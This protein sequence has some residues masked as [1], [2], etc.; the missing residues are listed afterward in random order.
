[1]TNRQRLARPGF[2]FFGLA[3]VIG[4]RS[5]TLQLLI[6]IGAPFMAV[7]FLIGIIAYASAQDEISE[8]YDSQLIRSAQ[9]LWTMIR[10][11]DDTDPLLVDRRDPNLD[12][13]DQEALDD[14]GRRSS[15][16]VWRDGRLLMASQGGPFTA[17]A[18]MPRGFTTM[19]TASGDWRVFTFVVP[20]DGI[21]VE[22]SE[23]LSARREV[24]S[25][26]VWGVSLPLLV[27]LP[28]IIL[29]VWLA[30]RWGLRDLRRFASDI[31]SRSPDDL[32]RVGGAD[33]PVEIAPVAEAV[34]QLLDKLERSAAQ[35]RLFTDNAAH[36]L[37]T[38]LA[39][40]VV[41]ADVI[42]NATTDA[43]RT[44]MI[45]ELSK[46]VARA[47]RLLDQLL[48][49][50]RIRHTPVEAQPLQLYDLAGEVIR[51]HY[52]KAR[53]RQIELSLSG[54]EA[55]VVTS[56]KAMLGL[57]IGNLVDNAIK[58]SPPGTA[59]EVSVTFEAE[60]ACLLVRDQGPGIPEHERDQVFNR[61]YRMKGQGETG[62]GL[63]LSIV[64]TLGELLSAK[65]TLFTPDTD[66]GLG[67]RV[68]FS[69]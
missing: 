12:A 10:Q 2:R 28:I 6:A 46:G 64:R 40:L 17:S 9:Q 56:S 19:R 32:S 7:I 30:I 5:L 25:R 23:R 11:D 43:D 26:I 54:D 65:I 16:R 18:P 1:M 47:S 3:A 22:A 69:R 57:L 37:R 21:V 55:V 31:H 60:G 51:D 33:L 35:E 58:Y 66:R 24:S 44:A 20:R 49:L 36:E 15:F 50:A 68:A 53:A 34:D 4:R 62:S 41:Q 27:V 67:V 13:A 38:P 59:V 8:V 14:Y 42:R 52:P 61:F 29:M 45:D 39:A 63:G 48:V